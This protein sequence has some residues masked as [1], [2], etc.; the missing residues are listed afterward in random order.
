ADRAKERTL[1]LDFERLDATGKVGRWILNKGEIAEWHEDC[2]ARL[3]MLKNFEHALSNPL[4]VIWTVH[5][6]GWMG[7]I[8]IAEQAREI[9]W[10][11]KGEPTFESTGHYSQAMGPNGLPMPT[12]TIDMHK[13][14]PKTELEIKYVNLNGEM[15]GPFTEVFQPNQESLDQ[16]K[17]ILNM[18]KT[19]WVAFNEYDG[20]LL[21]YFT[22]LLCYAEVSAIRYGLDTETPDQAYDVPQR[23][24][25]GVIGIG[26]DVDCYIVVP[27]TT[28][29]ACVQVTFDDGETTDVEI[30]Y[31]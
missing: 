18:T 11:K 14:A 8:Q 12:M 27:A 17:R 6:A 3:A 30:F 19:A 1:L 15:M 4:S 28:Q 16:T 29:T 20:R 26:A 21:L 13:R 31:R 24:G 25:V 2:A 5:N 9:F 22:H 23:E 7:T 10:R